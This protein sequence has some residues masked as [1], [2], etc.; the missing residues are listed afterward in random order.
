MS[1][2]PSR[3]HKLKAQLDNLFFAASYVFS[4]FMN[5]KNIYLY[6]SIR[7]YT[8]NM[9]QILIYKINYIFCLS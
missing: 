9:L 4:I 5:M 6:T 1:L 3:V 7:K 8:G 2:L